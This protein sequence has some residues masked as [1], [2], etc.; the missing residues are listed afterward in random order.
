MDSWKYFVVC[1]LKVNELSNKRVQ[2]LI[3]VVFILMKRFMYDLVMLG[4]EISEQFMRVYL[5]IVFLII[6]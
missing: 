6:K 2:L 4:F 1:G 5:L 3:V